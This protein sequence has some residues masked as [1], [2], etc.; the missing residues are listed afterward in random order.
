MWSGYDLWLFEQTQG[1]EQ[2]NGS[3][4]ACHGNDEAKRRLLA[5]W[6]KLLLHVFPNLIRRA[7]GEVLEGVFKMLVQFIHDP[8]VLVKVYAP[9]LIGFYLFQGR[10]R[11]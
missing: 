7:Y 11:A 1:E 4:H 8:I 10:F 2:G 5:V 6:R 9:Y 3:G